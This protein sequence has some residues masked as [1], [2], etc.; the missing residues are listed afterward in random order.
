MWRMSALIYAVLQK[1]TTINL[2][3][4]RTFVLSGSR[5]A[6]EIVHRSSPV[7]ANSALINENALRRR[8]R[9]GAGVRRCMIAKADF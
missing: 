7:Q 1:L 3:A 6:R 5:C 4:L 8:Q 2:R 9:V